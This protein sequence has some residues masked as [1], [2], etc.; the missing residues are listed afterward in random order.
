M[1]TSTGAPLGPAPEHNVMSL[2]DGHVGTTPDAVALRWVEAEVAAAHDGLGRLEHQGISWA[3]LDLR[4]RRAA[5][6]LAAR[7]FGAGDRALIFVPMSVDLYVAMFATF[8]L[9]GVAVFLDSFA[10]QHQ[11]AAC[12][13]LAEPAAYFGNQEAH[14][15][16]MMLADV[17][18]DIPIQVV[19]GGLD[20]PGAVR[21]DEVE[22]VGRDE[23]LPQQAIFPVTP[24]TTALVTFTTGSSGAPKGANRTH[25]FLFAQHH[26]LDRHVSYEPG[27]ADLPAFPIFLLNNLAAGI[28]TVIPAIDLARPAD[29]DAARIVSQLRHERLPCATFSPALLGAWCRHAVQTGQPLPDLRRVLTGGAPVG[30]ALVRDFHAAAPAAELLILYGSTEAEPIAHITGRDSL[31]HLSAETGAQGVCVGRVVSELRRRL[32]RL[33]KGPLVLDGR[34]WGAWDQPDGQPGELLVAGE[35]VC[36]GYWRNDDAF[37]RA[38]VLDPD[39][40]TVWHRTGDVGRFDA[41]GRLWLVGRVHNAVLRAGRHHFPVGPEEVLRAVPGAHQGAYLGLPDPDPA[42]ALGE[43]A[44]IAYVPTSDAPPDLAQHIKGALDQAG[45]TY[46]SVRLV[47]RIPMDPRHHSKVDYDRLRQLLTPASPPPRDPLRPKNE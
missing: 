36:R 41:Q 43:L 19:T 6:G 4:V 21:L 30:P 15:V 37:A 31:V 24:D 45:V 9:G 29:T 18:G 26:A 13:S 3:E 42:S 35:H 40:R 47:D 17:L 22:A 32:V 2:L 1:D 34:G 5:A 39:G 20:A 7:G 10:R 12:A 8:R 38:K 27:D 33:T 46:D 25:G 16:R 44:V 11:L 23:T 28:T 14:G